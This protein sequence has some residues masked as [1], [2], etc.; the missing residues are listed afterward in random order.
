MPLYDFHCSHCGR[1]NLDVYAKL[2]D[3]TQDCPCGSTMKRLFPVQAA[4]GARGD[5]EPYYDEVLDCDISSKKEK[6]RI[7][8]ELDLI[9]AGDAV[10]GART[11]DPRLPRE[12]R[13]EKQPPKGRTFVNLKAQSAQDFELMLETR[14]QTKKVR[15]NELPDVVGPVD[16]KK[17]KEAY[18][19]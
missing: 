9:E 7:L 10:H 12:S 5:L 15:F 14:G 11:F 19:L 6:R 1:T 2:E 3:R 13:L 4:L 18:G 16:R 17:A 8:R